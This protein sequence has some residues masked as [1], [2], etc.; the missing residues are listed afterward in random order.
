MEHLV[1]NTDTRCGAI[2]Q[3]NGSVRWRVWAPK[4]DRV[5]VALIS[6]RRASLPYDDP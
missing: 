3:N 2:V 4:A 6:W 5:E 1:E